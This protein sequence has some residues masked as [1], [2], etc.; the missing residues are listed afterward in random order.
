[1]D[2][3]I[4]AGQPRRNIGEHNLNNKFSEATERVLRCPTLALKT[5][6]DEAVATSMGFDTG[7]LTSR[8]ASSTFKRLGTCESTHILQ[9]RSA[10]ASLCFS[11]ASVYLRVGLDDWSRPSHREAK[12]TSP[13]VSAKYTPAIIVRGVSVNS[14]FDQVSHTYA[15]PLRVQQVSGWQRDQVGS[16]STYRLSCADPVAEPFSMRLLSMKLDA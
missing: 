4:A 15:F 3:G 1:M 10:I 9:A 5:W 2:S 6:N 8:S 7:G 13:C 14:I 12:F 16:S 11:R